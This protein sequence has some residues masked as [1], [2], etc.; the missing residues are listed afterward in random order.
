VVALGR[1]RLD[2][3]ILFVTPRF[4]YPLSK[5]DQLRVYHAIRALAARHEI[6]LVSAADTPVAPESLA[7]M[8]KWC[9][10]IEVVA[11]RRPIAALRIARRIAF[12]KLPLQVIYFDS[13][14]LRAAVVRALAATR[15]DAIHAQL[16]R[17]LP[18][19]WDVRQPPVVVDLMDNFAL[20]IAGRRDRA[21]PFARPLYDLERRRIAAYERSAVERF[22]E[23]VVAAEGDRI[24]LGGGA[25]LTTVGNGVDVANF[26][27]AD[28][29]RRDHQTAIMTGNM[30]YGPNVDAGLWFA[31]DVWP[32]VRA[33][34]PTARLRFVGAAP[35]AALRAL[36]GRDGIEV[37]GAVRNVA[38]ELQ[39]ATLA[40]CPMR[41]GTGVQNKVLEALST[42]TALVT[43]TLGN[44]GVGALADR[45]LL[46]ADEPATMASATLALFDDPARRLAL[47]IAGRTLMETTYDWNAHARI[48]EAIYAR[49]IATTAELAATTP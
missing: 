22:P 47:G 21:H 33:T 26:G 19:V 13:A 18:H 37:T 17:V 49:A 8:R 12:S 42:G 23:L 9:M 28:A 38:A 44:R 41:T 39:T 48:L 24:A 45:D 31:R 36:D 15:Y 32:L 6:G 25:H 35:A 46:V 20:S 1:E 27:Y 14:R 16:L 2:V 3:R 29:S 34:R 11:V 43:T 30:G 5:G 40:V 7:E 10:W 4:P